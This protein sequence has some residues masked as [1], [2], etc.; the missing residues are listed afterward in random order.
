MARKKK[1]GRAPGTGSVYRLPGNRRR[2]WVAVITTGWETVENKAKQL[3]RVLGYYEDEKAAND[4]LNAFNVNPFIMRSDLT[5]SELHDEWQAIHY[6]KVN[7]LTQRHYT[8]GYKHL[9]HM[10]DFQFSE[11]R[12]GQYEKVIIDMHREG[13]SASAMNQVL[14]VAKMLC[15]Y[16]V[17]NDITLRNYAQGIRVPR[18]TKKVK[19]IYTDV[20]IKVLKKKADTIDNLDLVLMLIYTG[21]RLQELLNLTKFDIDLSKNVITAGI[22]TDAGKGRTIPIH[23]TIR[24]MVKQRYNQ[25]GSYFIHWNENATKPMSQQ[26]FREIYYEALDTAQVPRR[27]PH[28]CRHTFATMLS[29]AGT[30]IT[31]IQRLMGHTDYAMTANQYT[32]V[33]IERMRDE[34]AGI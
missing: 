18:T 17:Q 3:R 2:S 30:P 27:T 1:I 12:R 26:K 33:D 11:I 15:E 32:H 31:T 13:Y 29:N 5:L 28:A 19:E 6:Q 7:L 34:M 23:K 14:T 22:K 25:P 20:D 24:D 21:L 16:A 10:A 4:A 8:S 9:S